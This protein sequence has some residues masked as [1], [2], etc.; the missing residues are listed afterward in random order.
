MTFVARDQFC[1]GFAQFWRTEIPA[2]TSAIGPK[3]VIE[4]VELGRTANDP[5]RSWLNEQTVGK[6]G[7]V[8]P[9][10]SNVFP[11]GWVHEVTYM[12]PQVA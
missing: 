9:M 4:V 3:A 10:L 12:G 6:W 1:L 11:E 2:E 7:Y 8:G 5:M